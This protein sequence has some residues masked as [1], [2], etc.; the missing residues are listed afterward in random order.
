M[1]EADEVESITEL[2]A[3]QHMKRK[4]PDL[5]KPQPSLPEYYG[6]AESDL[7]AYCDMMQTLHPEVDDPIHLETDDNS[8]VLAG[9]ERQHGVSAFLRR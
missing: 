2:L 5:S 4:K 1:Q 3:W 7:S 6:T 9:H 8:L